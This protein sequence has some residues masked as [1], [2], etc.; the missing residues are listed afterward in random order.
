MGTSFG[1]ASRTTG[2]IVRS[3]PFRC[4]SCFHLDS[5]YE[6]SLQDVV[7]RVWVEG[8]GDSSAP[9]HDQFVGCDVAQHVRRISR[10]A[11][12]L[13]KCLVPGVREVTT[14]A[15]SAR[16]AVVEVQIAGQNQPAT[17]LHAGLTVCVCIAAILKHEQAPN[18]SARVRRAASD[19][20]S[21]VRALP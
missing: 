8:H 18:Y 5:F 6:R 3:L 1:A 4:R 9:A 14:C 20:S 15:G 13:E 2:L 7:N 17:T 16:V 10:T 21:F 11:L 19:I 12:Q